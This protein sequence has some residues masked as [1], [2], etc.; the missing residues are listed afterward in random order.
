[1]LRLLFVTACFSEIRFRRFM[2][3]SKMLTHQLS[4]TKECLGYRMDQTISNNI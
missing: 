3:Y 2:V 1:M 4:S